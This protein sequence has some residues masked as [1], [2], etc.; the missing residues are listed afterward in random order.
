ML[1]A[2]RRFNLARAISV[3]CPLLSDDCR[4]GHSGSR[5]SPALSSST[6]N[7]FTPF[8]PRFVLV[9]N[10]L[11]SRFLIPLPFPLAISIQLPVTISIWTKLRPAAARAAVCQ[12]LVR[13]RRPPARN[14]TAQGEFC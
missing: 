6:H 5:F 8:R 12:S 7:L 9:F 13:G 1:L 3:R 4:G 2:L 11:Q 10:P 14:D